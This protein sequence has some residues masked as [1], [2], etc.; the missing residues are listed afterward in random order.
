MDDPS[1]DF[2]TVNRTGTGHEALDP[3]SNVVIMIKIDRI[4]KN[5]KKKHAHAHTRAHARAHAH[6]HT[7]THTQ[8]ISQGVD[9]HWAI[10]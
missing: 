6:T 4:G 10:H 9:R 8:I 1:K 3:T 2:Y 5:Q 7:H